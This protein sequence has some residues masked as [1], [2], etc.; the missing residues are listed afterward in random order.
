MHCVGVG[1]SLTLTSLWGSYFDKP[2]GVGGESYLD[3]PGEQEAALVSIVK[4]VPVILDKLPGEVAAG[5]TRT[6]NL[7]L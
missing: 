1:A 4:L 6:R 5:G 2:V 3:K 7:S